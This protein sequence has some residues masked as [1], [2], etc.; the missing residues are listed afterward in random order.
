MVEKKEPA[1]V[2]TVPGWQSTREVCGIH[3]EDGTRVFSVSASN[4]E[5]LR[6]VLTFCFNFCG[7]VQDLM[8]VEKK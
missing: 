6:I 2:F 3:F 4:A 5:E 7:S 8:G 1:Q